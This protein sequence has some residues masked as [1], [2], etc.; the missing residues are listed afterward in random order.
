MYKATGLLQE[1]G[2]KLFE[3]AKSVGYD[4][5]AAFRKAFKRVLGVAPKNIDEVPRT[6]AEVEAQ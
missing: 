2:R 5:D 4:S 3:V 1:N 6:R